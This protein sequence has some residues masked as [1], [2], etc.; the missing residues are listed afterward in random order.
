MSDKHIIWREVD[1]LEAFQGHGFELWYEFD[2]VPKNDFFIGKLLVAF[3]H[4][5]GWYYGSKKPVLVETLRPSSLEFTSRQLDGERIAAKAWKLIL[6]Y[7]RE[8]K[9]PRHE[10]RLGGHL[11]VRLNA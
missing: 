8:N 5:Y 2:K 6:K 11:Q 4:E 7:F 1:H 9:L 10:A 3:V